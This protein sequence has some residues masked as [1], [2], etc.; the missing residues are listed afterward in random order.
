MSNN[1]NFV[2][3]ARKFWK[4]IKRWFWGGWW[5]FSQ[6]ALIWYALHW[7]TG[8]RFLPVRLV[9]YFM[10]WLLAGLIPGLAAAGLARRRWLALAL[11]VPTAATG[12]TF[13]P[14]FLPPLTTALASGTS[15]KIMSYNVWYKNA[16][17]S[18]LGQVIRQE[19]PDILFLQELT[20]PIVNR[21]ERE[22]ADLYPEGK[23]YLAYE[24]RTYQGIISRY[25]L[26]PLNTAEDRAEAQKVRV[27]TP[28]GTIAVWNIHPRP[29]LPW[30]RQ[31]KHLAAVAKQ[32]AAIDGPLIVAGDF[33]TT[34]QSETYRLVN[35]YLHNAHWQAGWGF[36]FTFPAHAPY[37]KGIPVIIPV[38]RI[39]HIFYSRHFFARHARTLSESGGS[40]HFP[41]VAELSL[42]E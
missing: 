8:D 23:L 28:I 11:I 10:P 13:A 22:L 5:L 34:D 7:W 41:V 26:T 3:Q 27:Q 1:F 21:L 40:D 39:D 25:P 29:P 6:N 19:R 35:R 37:L 12:L 38:I 30:S 32:I 31:Y 14:L 2:F 9:N 33:N 15:F 16:D 18:G 4:I 24:P 17:I 20:P 36:G 42:I